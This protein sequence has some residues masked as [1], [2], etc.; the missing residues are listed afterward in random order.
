MESEEALM[1]KVIASELV[2]L[3]GVVE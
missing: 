1:R 3:D 2:S